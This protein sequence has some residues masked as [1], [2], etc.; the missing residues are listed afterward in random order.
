[1]PSPQWANDAVEQTYVMRRWEA[2]DQGISSAPGI[3]DAGPPVARRSRPIALLDHNT[4]L[5][6]VPL[7]GG[8][9]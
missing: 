3:K 4:T 8:I 5:A 1:M 9:E 2:I 6:R 7:L